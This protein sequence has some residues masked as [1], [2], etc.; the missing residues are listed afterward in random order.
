VYATSV[1]YAFLVA[2][3]IVTVVAFLLLERWWASQQVLRG[4]S[5]EPPWWVATPLFLNPYFPLTVG[6]FAK[7]EV[8]LGLGVSLALFLGIGLLAAVLALRN[9]RRGYEDV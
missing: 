9:L 7:E 2:L 3:S 8:I 6:R 4:G 5:Q 1:T